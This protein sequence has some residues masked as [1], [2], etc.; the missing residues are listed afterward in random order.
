MLNMSPGLSILIILFTALFARSF[1]QDQHLIPHFLLPGMQPIIFTLR[2]RKGV[3]MSK[4]EK[5]PFQHFCCDL[6]PSKYLFSLV[7][8]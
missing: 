7:R 3:C 1:S 5:V 6:T 4:S 8:M 2:S